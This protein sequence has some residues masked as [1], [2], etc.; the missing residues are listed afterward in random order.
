M[1]KKSILIG[2]LIIIL[3]FLVSGC[4]VRFL[5]RHPKDQQTIAVLS[6]EIER[7]KRLHSLEKMQLESAMRRLREDLETQINNEAV[8]VRMSEDKGLVITL[9]TE[10]LFDSGKADIKPEAEQALDDIINVLEE[11]AITQDIAIEGHTD[12]VPIM[13]SAYKSNW[14]LSSARAMSVLYYLEDSGVDPVKMKATGYGEYR[15]VASND[16]AAGRQKNRRVEI[17]I[18]P[19]YS[20]AQIRQIEFEQQKLKKQ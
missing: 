10:I 4:E 14:E 3:C 6:A 18:V 19:K 2:T 9:L 15:P 16:T 13:L 17:I 8:S 7:L 11:E 1:Y 5:K 20:D 12:N